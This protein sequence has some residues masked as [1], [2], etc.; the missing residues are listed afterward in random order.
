MVGKGGPAEGLG[1][2]ISPKTKRLVTVGPYRYSRNPM[3]FGAF[4]LYVSVAIVCNSIVCLACLLIFL[5]FGIGYLK[6]SEETRL[7][8]DF[9]DEFREYRKKV[10][11]LFPVRLFFR[12]K[13]G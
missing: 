2:A 9:G 11:M 5:P 13:R 4:M 1:I 10:P 6:F 3:V 7:L 8:K 12:R